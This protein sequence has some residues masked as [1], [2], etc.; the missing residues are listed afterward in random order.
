MEFNRRNVIGA[1][2]AATAAACMGTIASRALAFDPSVLKPKPAPVPAAVKQAEPPSLLRQA[3]AA[4]DT[5]A[6]AQ[7]DLIGLVDFSVHSSWPRFQLVDLAGGAILGAYLVAH[8]RGSDPGHTGWLQHFSNEPGS[9]ASSRGS[10]L[11]A[12]RYTGQ[13]GASRRLVGLDPENDQA[14]PRAIVIHGAGYV[15]DALIHTQGHIGRSQGCFALAESC[16]EDV[17]ARLG[18]GRLLFAAK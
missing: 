17:L 9:N 12:H 6:I 10:Y 8:G 15:D 11:V 18:E 14:L 7:R 1:T 3:M 16:I 2:A 13:H 5:H 4:L